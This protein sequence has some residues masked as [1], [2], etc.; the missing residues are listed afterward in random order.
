MKKKHTKLDFCSWQD[1]FIKYKDTNQYWVYDLCTDKIHVS[2]SIKVNKLSL[3]KWSIKKSY[4]NDDWLTDDNDSLNKLN[5]FSSTSHK[6]LD[7]D[8]SDNNNND[9]NY[10]IKTKNQQNAL[11]AYI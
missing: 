10:V 9:V 5:K 6:R 2:W 8:N 4:V 11:K 1:I 3:Y 7:N